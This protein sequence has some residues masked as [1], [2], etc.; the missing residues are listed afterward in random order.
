MEERARHE[1]G[2]GA[3]F[4]FGLI[5]LGL[6]AY[7][8]NYYGKIMRTS[9]YT[10][11]FDE[12]A[13][14]ELG[15][16]VLLGGWRAGEV[17]RVEVKPNGKVF[18]D[19]G[20]NKK[21]VL[22]ENYIY[23][24]RSGFLL[25]KPAIAIHTSPGGGKV[26]PPGSLIVATNPALPED[27]VADVR[28]ALEDAGKSLEQAN[29]LIGDPVLHAAL[30]ETFTNLSKASENAVTMTSAL[31][32]TSSDTRAA[33]AAVLA[34]LKATAHNLALATNSVGELAS[35]PQLSQD[36]LRMT[37][38]LQRASENVEALTSKPQLSEAV[39]NLGV[40]SRDLK[41]TS[42][43]LSDMLVSG[44]GLARISETLVSAQ[45]AAE[46][47][48]VVAGEVKG[49]VESP[50]ATTGLK[51]TLSN[52]RAASAKALE[53]AGRANA[54]LS[55]G[56]KVIGPASSLQSTTRTDM[57]FLSGADR[58]ESDVE[59]RLRLPWLSRELIVGAQDV[60]EASALNLKAGLPSGKGSQVVWGIHRSKL[61]VGWEG[62]V[63]GRLGLTIDFYD[64]NRLQADLWTTWQLSPSVYL[65]AGGVGL[66]EKNYGGFGVGLRK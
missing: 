6:F 3:V 25:G 9:V 22:R 56:E 41:E 40:V 49:L 47:L 12:V 36:I 60:G 4:I 28:K 46:K 24:I 44:N 50:E 11:V 18:V 55:A 54:L 51:E 20:V 26:I 15:G 57:Y 63:G 29:R 32:S 10:L 45:E 52:A 14:I 59:L 39:E 17:V 62:D 13:G 33:A 19:I 42:R 2:V 30:R 7:F 5:L 66:G 65:A 38:N 16:D 61:G 53:A 64:P 43:A 1:L 35:N 37:Q 34:D 21:C 8:A 58:L 27:V 48:N 23:T 31:A